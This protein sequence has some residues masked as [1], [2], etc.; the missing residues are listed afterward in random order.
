[1]TSPQ[2]RCGF[3]IRE[4]QHHVVFQHLIHRKKHIAVRERVA[5]LNHVCYC[6]QATAAGAF[7]TL[8]ETKNKT[9]PSRGTLAAA[10][11]LGCLLALVLGVFGAVYLDQFRAHTGPDI[12]LRKT[13]PVV[14]S[15]TPPEAGPSATVTPPENPPVAQAVTPPE[16][17][18]PEV[19]QAQ[20][21]TASTVTPLADIAP[22]L[23]Q[24]APA[25]APAMV[26]AAAGPRYWVEFGVYE[27]KF[28]ADKLTKSLD[29]L[30]IKATIT[31]APGRNGTRYL[32]VRTANESDQA[33]AEAQ[34]EKARTAF[35]ITPLLHRT[36]AAATIAPPKAAVAPAATA[37][38]PKPSPK[39]GAYWVQFGAYSSEQGAR[40]I[41]NQLAKSGIQA[42]VTKKTIQVP[43]TLYLIRAEGL[44]DR[45]EATSVAQKG[46]AVLHSSDAFVR[47]NLRAP[48]LPR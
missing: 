48:P 45:A 39:T 28:F 40:E 41:A 33:T 38:A 4:M 24:I 32:R 31:T 18:A 36:A 15:A 34:V 43:Q 8:Y 11:L 9:P 1:M 22:K 14:A 19:A 5:A 10:L 42:T 37:S 6:F 20:P 23:E 7:R 30:G 17:P 25:A 29:D 47:K 26:A 12:V 21:T 27:G 16:S 2:L 35:K 44:P 3:C 13:A 46:S